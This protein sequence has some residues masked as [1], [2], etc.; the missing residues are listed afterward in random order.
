[1]EKVLAARANARGARLSP[2][3][4]LDPGDCTGLD[5][6]SAGVTMWGM[7]VRIMEGLNPR[8]VSAALNATLYKNQG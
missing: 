3:K 8:P 1:M 2:A 6:G 4:L 7:G 5:P